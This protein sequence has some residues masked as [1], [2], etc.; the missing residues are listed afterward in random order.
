MKTSTLF[1]FNFLTLVYL[2]IKQKANFVFPK[3]VETCYNQ[4]FR[5]HKRYKFHVTFLYRIELLSVWPEGTLKLDYGGWRDGSEVL[6]ALTD[7]AKDSHR[8]RTMCTSV[9]EDLMP[10][11][12]L[13]T[14]CARCIDI[15]M[16]TCRRD[17]ATSANSTQRRI[18]RYFNVCSFK[19]VLHPNSSWDRVF[20]LALTVLN[21]L[22]RPG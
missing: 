10:L 22:Y 5:S 17:Y 2:P 6:R 13:S 1:F 20:S 18:I 21:S 3:S 4:Q 11:L 8:L 14:A 16:H 12:T 7:L 15:Q 9:P 19:E